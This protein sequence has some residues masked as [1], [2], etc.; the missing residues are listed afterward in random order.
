MSLVIAEAARGG[1]GRPFSRS[2]VVPEA[3]RF[4]LVS[5]RSRPPVREPS[6]RWR[7]ERDQLC[8]FEGSV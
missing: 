7:P 5:G 6:R 4:P 8:D 3:G 2:R 1:L